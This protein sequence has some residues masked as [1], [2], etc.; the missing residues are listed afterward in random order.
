MD[1][2][3]ELTKIVKGNVDVTDET[4]RLYS[5]DASVFEMMP[6]AVVFVRDEADIQALVRFVAEHKRTCRH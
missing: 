4:R 1:L 3:Q 2:A 6:Q 5:H